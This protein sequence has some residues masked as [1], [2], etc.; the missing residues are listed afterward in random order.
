MTTLIADR[1]I[2]RVL[3]SLI[4]RRGTVPAED[5]QEKEGGRAERGRKEKYNKRSHGRS[6]L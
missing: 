6:L 5:R 2:V 1:K 3:R 4:A